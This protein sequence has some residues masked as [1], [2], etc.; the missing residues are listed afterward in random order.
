[1]RL[2]FKL[3]QLT[4]LIWANQNAF[5]VTFDS[6]IKLEKVFTK[7]SSFLYLQFSKTIPHHFLILLA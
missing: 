2:W 3:M 5:T 1:M 6:M 7:L 4:N